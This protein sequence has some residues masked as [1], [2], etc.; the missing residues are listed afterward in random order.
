MPSSHVILADISLSLPSG[1]P[2][3]NHCT[4]AVTQRV[5]A[6]VGRNGIGKSTLGRIISGEILPDSGAITLSGKL[7]YVPQS[8]QGSANVS[9]ASILGLDVIFE[10]LRRIE[11]GGIAPE[12][13]ELETEKGL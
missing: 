2:L 9:V 10:A 1:E 6:L 11:Q 4:F 3:F 7:N 13:Q 12:D 5:S 8:W